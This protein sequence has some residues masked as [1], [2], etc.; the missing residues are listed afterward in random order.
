MD[1]T[2]R[3]FFSDSGWL[4]WKRSSGNQ[5]HWRQGGP[6]KGQEKVPRMNRADNYRAIG[7]ATTLRTIIDVE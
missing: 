1:W 5:Q 6:M 3:N 4:K 2:H 7:L